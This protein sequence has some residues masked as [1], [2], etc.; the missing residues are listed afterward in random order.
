MERVQTRNAAASTTQ[1]RQSI[2]FGHGPIGNGI[3]MNHTT[4]VLGALAIAANVAACGNPH[5]SA[6]VNESQGHTPIAQQTATTSAPS[7]IALAP[8]TTDV[9]IPTVKQSWAAQPDVF[10]YFLATADSERGGQIG[11]GE[12]HANTTDDS[13]AVVKAQKAAEKAAIDNCSK[14]GGKDCAI[15]LPGDAGFTYIPSQADNAG[16]VN[17]VCV[18]VF[19]YPYQPKVQRYLVMPGQ[20]RSAEVAMGYATQ[21]ILNNSDADV[22]NHKVVGSHCL[23]AI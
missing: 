22:R 20:A 2:K 13:G 1:G 17:I 14:A 19:D 23:S 15:A 5:P 18:A 10:M 9:P 11:F 21:S 8:T 7:S 12:G 16:M 3:A 4:R 6:N